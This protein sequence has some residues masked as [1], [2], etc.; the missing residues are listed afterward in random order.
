M[1]DRHTVNAMMSSLIDGTLGCLDAAAATINERWGRDTSKGTLSK[2]LAGHL[3][4][5]IADIVAL[6]D[7]V[8]RYPVTRMLA[9]RLR[10][11][12]GATDANMIHQAGQI[13][14]EA[15][16]AVA[17]ILAAEQSANAEH[18]AKAITEIDEAIVA[19]QLARDRLEGSSK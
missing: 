18:A 9:R 15:G 14:R 7:A 4:W 12:V 16:E 2:K 19:L 17:A 1:A 10:R 6:E 5:T 11:F 13:S 8:G 3:D